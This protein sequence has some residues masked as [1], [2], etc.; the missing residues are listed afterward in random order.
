MYRPVSKENGAEFEGEWL[1]D[2]ELGVFV[3]NDIED[4]YL[5]KLLPIRRRAHEALMKR[6]QG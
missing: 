5:Y 1:G 4:E 3:L 2:I 6:S